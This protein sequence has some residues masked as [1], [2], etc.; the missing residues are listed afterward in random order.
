MTTHSKRLVTRY[1]TYDLSSGWNK[2][3]EPTN[4]VMAR[5][6][7]GLPPTLSRDSPMF[8]TPYRARRQTGGTHEN[9]NPHPQ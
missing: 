7:Q 4:Q 8:L 9:S 2:R 1:R 5:V 3:C 6:R